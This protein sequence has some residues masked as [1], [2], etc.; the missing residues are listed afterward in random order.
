MRALKIITGHV[1]SAGNPDS[2]K[3]GFTVF[4]TIWK[5]VR[6]SLRFSRYKVRQNTL[7]Y[8][9]KPKPSKFTLDLVFNSK[10]F[11][12]Y[13]SDVFHLRIFNL[14]AYLALFVMV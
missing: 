1:Q 8:K 11:S 12:Y 13:L 6:V 3:V 14:A 10:H 5:R 4:L 7:K 9:S 2:A